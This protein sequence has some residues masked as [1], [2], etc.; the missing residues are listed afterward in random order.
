MVSLIASVKSRP[1]HVKLNLEEVPGLV[2]DYFKVDN[3]RTDLA[4]FSPIF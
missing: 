4:E 2:R 1:S 3:T